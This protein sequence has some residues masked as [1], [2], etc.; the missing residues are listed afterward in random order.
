MGAPELAQR[1]CEACGP[2]TP[3]LSEEEAADLHRRI[4]AAWSREGNHVIRRRFGFGNFRD[5]FGF[6]TRVA[7]LAEGEG[8]HPD[9]DVGWGRVVLTLTT[10]AAGGLTPN[11][12]IMAAKIDQLSE[13]LGLKV[14]RRE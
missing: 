6:A 14:Q 3:A 1:R 11:D 7:L 5:A 10:H 9:V 13:G 12:F 8:H 2:G 4:D